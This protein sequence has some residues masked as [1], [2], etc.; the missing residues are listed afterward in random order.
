[1]GCWESVGVVCRHPSAAILMSAAGSRLLL[2]LCLPMLQ[3]RLPWQLRTHRPHGNRLRWQGAGQGGKRAFYYNTSSYS[4]SSP[5]YF[6][7]SSTL[8]LC[9][10]ADRLSAEER[11][12]IRASSSRGQR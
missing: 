9:A 8:L 10:H 5:S 11:P 6:S 1:M 7:F 4:N 12:R 3:R 2:G